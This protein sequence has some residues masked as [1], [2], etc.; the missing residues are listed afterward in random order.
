MITDFRLLFNKQITNYNCNNE[1]GINASLCL[2]LIFIF[3]NC[4]LF[5][6]FD[7]CVHGPIKIIK[8]FE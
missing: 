2:I 3:T 7:Q 8:R 1:S 6:D 4:Y 5:S